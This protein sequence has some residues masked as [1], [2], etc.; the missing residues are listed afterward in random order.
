M[1]ELH[2]NSSDLNELTNK[3][4]GDTDRH[5]EC[6]DIFQLCSKVLKRTESSNF[7]LTLILNVI[8]F[9]HGF[10]KFKCRHFQVFKK[11]KSSENCFYKKI[12]CSFYFNF[13]M[14]G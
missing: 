10:H 11:L 13:V 8:I 1:Y 4:T 3:Y 14:L 2:S 5:V 6:I 7:K 9:L 12:F